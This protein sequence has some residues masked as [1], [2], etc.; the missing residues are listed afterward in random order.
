VSIR[1]RTR[2]VLEEK[3]GR[4]QCIAMYYEKVVMG[5]MPLTDN[6]LVL[7]TVDATTKNFQ[8]IM[9]KV[10]RLISRYYIT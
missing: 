10:L 6:D 3:L 9:R 4:A 2:T 8:V 5:S 1:H 7:V